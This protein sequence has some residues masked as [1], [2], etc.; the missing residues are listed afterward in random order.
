MLYQPSQNSTTS[1]AKGGAAGI[2]PSILRVKIRAKSEETPQKTRVRTPSSAP[3]GR[4]RAPARSRPSRSRQDI[5]RPEPPHRLLT[6]LQ[7][8]SQLGQSPARSLLLLFLLLRAEARRRRPI[9]SVELLEQ[10][11][12]A[13]IHLSRHLEPQQ[14]GRRLAGATGKGQGEPPQRGAGG[15]QLP[16][17]NGGSSPP[18]RPA[19]SALPTG[20]CSL[21]SLRAPEAQC[22][23]EAVVLRRAGFPKM[24]TPPPGTKS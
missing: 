1:S 21:R 18:Q 10:L 12:V 4:R 16:A 7:P 15:L 19:S 2:E 20:R 24:G 8:L 3:F 6:A 5:L 14:E 17:C 13:E 23:L 22:T 9:L 11:A